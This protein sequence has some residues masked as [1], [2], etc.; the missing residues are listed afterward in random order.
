MNDG[1]TVIRGATVEID[2]GGT[3]V[4]ALRD[5]TV[6]IS[7]DK[8]P[9]APRTP[10]E[11]GWEHSDPGLLSWKV[12]AEWLRLYHYATDTESAKRDPGQEALRRSQITRTT[13]KVTIT[14][15]DGI[16]KYGYATIVGYES[17]KAY[18]DL[19]KG[20]FT[21]RGAGVLSEEEIP[22]SMPPPDSSPG[23]TQPGIDPT[24]GGR[25]VNVRAYGAEGNGISD[26]TE[27]ITNAI[28][29]ARR[30]QLGV[31]FP[32]GDYFVTGS[33]PLY[34]DMAWVGDG[35]A[36]QQTYF[37]ELESINAISGGE[38]ELYVN[39]P[40]NRVTHRMMQGDPIKVLSCDKEGNNGIHAVKGVDPE[41]SMVRIE[42]PSAV[43]ETF[44]TD[45]DF[46]PKSDDPQTRIA[47]PMGG[48]I[49]RMQNIADGSVHT[50]DRFIDERGLRHVKLRDIGFVG[51]GI[52]E[53]Y[54]GG[55][56]FRRERT[57]RAIT[58]FDFEE[59]S[60]EHIAMDAIRFDQLIH[61]TLSHLLIKR[62]V[63]DGILFEGA[64]GI[65]GA[66]TSVHIEAPYIQ[67]VRRGIASYISAYCSV[68][69]P[70]IE[71]TSI[72]YYFERAIGLTLN[73]PGS[74]TIKF[75]EA[76]SGFGETLRLI[77]CYGTTINSPTVYY[78]TEPGAW[79]KCAILAADPNRRV[80]AQA[81]VIT[82]GHIHI[83][84][85]EKI[86]AVATRWD[87]PTNRGRVYLDVRK[88][89]GYIPPD[90]STSSTWI[91]NSYWH[92][93]ILSVG[94]GFERDELFNERYDVTS[95]EKFGYN[96]DDPD[97]SAP[98]PPGPQ[99]DSARG[100]SF[101]D[102]WENTMLGGDDYEGF[103]TCIDA[104]EGAARWVPAQA[105]FEVNFDGRQ[106]NPLPKAPVARD[107]D[108]YLLRMGRNYGT[109]V[110]TDQ[111]YRVLE[112]KTNADGDLIAWLD[113]QEWLP[114]R[115]IATTNWNPHTS[116]ADGSHVSPTSGSWVIQ[117]QS[118]YEHSDGRTYLR[119]QYG[120]PSFLAHDETTW[121][122]TIRKAEN[123]DGEQ[124][125]VEFDTLGIE[126][127]VEPTYVS[128]DEASTSLYTYTPVEAFFEI[129]MQLEVR[130]TMLEAMEGTRTIEE[131]GFALSEVSSGGL[132]CVRVR[133][134]G[135]LI[136][137]NIDRSVDYGIYTHPHTKAPVTT[138]LSIAGLD[139]PLIFDPAEAI[140]VEG[141]RR[142]EVEFPDGQAT[143]TVPLDAARNYVFRPHIEGSFTQVR[144]VDADHR[145]VTF[146]R[147]DAIGT[148]T[149]TV[150]AQRKKQPGIEFVFDKNREMEIQ[151]EVTDD[152]DAITI[153]W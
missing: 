65:G 105:L 124:I 131:M 120:V 93:G 142:F 36:Y 79:S 83:S 115:Y 135:S 52:N 110:A 8:L 100:V 55:I 153:T 6:R 38:A 103:W 68:S 150:E 84:A 24:S 39:D 41:N 49:I 31:Y 86:R 70:V 140:N 46:Q 88:D 9:K 143:K 145:T 26:D 35:M 78:N 152:T 85:G 121:D 16:K 59:V 18:D 40:E 3:K 29:E 90:G 97:H 19:V 58:G 50:G 34:S 125:V 128:E 137:D 116:H 108:A 57:G 15:P 127:T 14:Y 101:G 102:V 27:A 12:N 92:D 139:A 113:I 148:E 76:G 126:H 95:I 147:D 146:E 17:G 136:E 104:T 48:S 80:E 73:S 25:Y 122:E 56:R 42:N 130:R 75:D 96:S 54:G 33:L 77:D 107:T 60:M 37:L 43:D 129:G 22:A 91:G 10:A 151:T 51:P 13:V 149:A 5:A 74:E 141:G 20:N 62:C 89:A 117:D 119:T 30:Q 133:F 11:Y 1:T 72:G 64:S 111:V 87:G 32:G 28:E 98:R 99:D 23:P 134:S 67:N 2:V 66:T 112:T 47:Y 114:V 106:Q 61:S 132:P 118:L 94:T 44:A 123:F 138:E 21:L 45:D 4:G 81:G 144:L 82:G 63:G 53:V 71:G 109:D 7:T 69:N